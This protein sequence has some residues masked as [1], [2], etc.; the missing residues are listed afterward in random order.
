MSNNALHCSQNGK[1]YTR[2]RN[3]DGKDKNIKFIVNFIVKVINPKMNTHLLVKKTERI[4]RKTPYSRGEI[5][6]ERPIEH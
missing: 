6:G 3:R 5:R 1:H 2:L 4:S